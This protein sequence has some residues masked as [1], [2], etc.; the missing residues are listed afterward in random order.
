[1]AWQHRIGGD[2]TGI[3][4]GTFYDYDVAAVTRL[5]VSAG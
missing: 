2:T 1:M 5:P 3:Q 4:L